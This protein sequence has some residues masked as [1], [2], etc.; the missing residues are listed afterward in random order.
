MELHE[1]ARPMPADGEPPRQGRWR[2]A[3][4]R[5]SAILFTVGLV[6]SLALLFHVPVRGGF[7]ELQVNAKD[8]RQQ[9]FT[10][11]WAYRV[12]SGDPPFADRGIWDAPIFYPE[13]HASSTGVALVGIAPFYSVLRALGLD[14]ADALQATQILLIALD[15][16][17]LWLLARRGLGL[18]PG[19]AMSA[20]FL[21][22]CSGARAATMNHFHL[23][24]QFPGVL[25]AALIAESVRRYGSLFASTW[26]LAAAGLLGVWQFWCSVYLGWLGALAAGALLVAGVFGRETRRTLRPPPVRSALLLAGLALVVAAALYPLADVYLQRARTGDGSSYAEVVRYLPRPFSWIS[27]GRGPWLWSDLGKTEAARELAS[28]LGSR[29]LGWGLVA[30]AIALAGMWISRRRGWARAAALASLALVVVATRWVGDASA[31][32]WVYDLVPGSSAI[33]DPGRIVHLLLV[34]WSLFFGVGIGWLAERFGRW[35][36]IALFLFSSLEQGRTLPS[37]PKARHLGVP[38]RI[39]DHLPPD[40]EAFFYSPGAG[41]GDVAQIDAMWAA[42]LA[43]RPTVNGLASYE[44]QAWQPLFDPRAGDP[45]AVTRLRTGLE[46]WL[47][48]GGGSDRSVCWLREPQVEGREFEIEWIRPPTG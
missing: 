20:A 4:P 31:W 15:Y 10:L 33:R 7:R 14:P 46:G 3:A 19:V 42:L 12:W 44:P 2:G 9:A 29:R 11:E 26:R 22:A 30:P 24:A 47:A 5:L 34:P 41:R 8:L 32:R 35:V 43:G 27:P 28:S 23:F 13:P 16:V 48:A 21:F 17:A 25:A 38:M 45:R 40:C 18:A 37:F 1:R 39:V 6:G 36:A